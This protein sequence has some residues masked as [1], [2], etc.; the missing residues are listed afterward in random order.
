MNYVSTRG[1]APALDF[2]AVTLAGLASDGGQ[3]Q[4][5]AVELDDDGVGKRALV[6]RDYD[7]EQIGARLAGLYDQQSRLK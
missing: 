4:H 3:L 5:R 6:E 2:A 7:A 1:A